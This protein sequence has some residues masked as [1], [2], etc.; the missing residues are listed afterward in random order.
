MKIVLNKPVLF[1]IT[2]REEEDMMAALH[3]YLD[4]MF[5]AN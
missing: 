1:D 4:F 2:T 3:D 5:F